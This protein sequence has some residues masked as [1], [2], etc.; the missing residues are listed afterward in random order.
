VVQQHEREQPGDLGLVGEG[1]ELAGD[2][3]RLGRQVDIPAVP[4]VEDQVEHP[5]HGPE[6]ARLVE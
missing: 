6:I 1:G 4:L 2:P 3:D 5:E